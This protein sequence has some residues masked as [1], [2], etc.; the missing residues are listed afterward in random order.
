[1]LCGCDN[2]IY[3]WEFEKDY[4]HVTAIQIIATPNGERF[5]ISTYIVVKEIDLSYASELMDDIEQIRMRTRGIN[6]VSP[7]GLG[8][9]FIFDNGEYDVISHI[10]ASHYRYDDN[11][12]I[13]EYS[14]W[15]AA[16]TD[17]LLDVISK[18][19]ALD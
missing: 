1:M 16:N 10:G 5:D 4:T 18:Y 8:I 12:Q 14:A 17:D 3:H 2:Q 15:L 13:Q 9:L 11:S 19:L 6:Y 7:S